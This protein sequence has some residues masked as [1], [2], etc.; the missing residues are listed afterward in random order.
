MTG[1]IFD[2]GKLSSSD[3]TIKKPL[4]L[5][6]FYGLSDN[7][8][9]LNMYHE[10]FFLNEFDS[11][12]ELIIHE[13]FSK[14]E[15][16]A[17]FLERTQ[18]EEISAATYLEA[19]LL[20][21]DLSL[22]FESKPIWLKSSL[23]SEKINLTSNSELRTPNLAIYILLTYHAARILIYRFEISSLSRYPPPDLYNQNSGSPQS[24]NLAL[25]ICW[26]SHKFILQSLKSCPILLDSNQI[27][28]PPVITSI[29]LQVSVF[30]CIMS[31]FADVKDDRDLALRDYN[32]LKRKISSVIP[33]SSIVKFLL[34]DLEKLER[35]PYGELK[36]KVTYQIFRYGIIDFETKLFAEEML[37]K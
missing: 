28:R 7:S 29:I 17:K 25:Q 8:N 11:E 13:L 16:I 18:Y 6:I 33:F 5:K 35:L 19:A 37:S 2:I 24:T 4:P 20:S 12:V 36:E 26:D 32:Y 23:N 31:M 1:K 27:Q 21:Q 10:D 9:E 22:W 34:E 14:I 15:E 3:I 30:S